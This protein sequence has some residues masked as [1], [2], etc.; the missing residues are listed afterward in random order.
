MGALSCRAAKLAAPIGVAAI[1][2]FATPA[3]AETS[4][5]NAADTA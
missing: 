2:A 3:F 4:G 1:T 5:I